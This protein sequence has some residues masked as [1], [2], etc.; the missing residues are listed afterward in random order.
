MGSLSAVL[1]GAAVMARAPQGEIDAHVAPRQPG[2]NQAGARP[3]AVTSARGARLLFGSA[4]VIGRETLA[5]VWGQPPTKTFTIVGVARDTDT[6]RRMSRSEATL[7]VPLAQ[8]YEPNLVLV[9]RTNGD[10]ANAAHILQMAVR[11]ADPDLGTGSSGPAM[12]LLAGQ[13]VAARVGG[14][15]PAALGAS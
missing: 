11:K 3:V 7:Y 1:L 15:L 13:F 5:Q 10:P 12:M 9:A 6:D 4:D 14:L 2:E 8:H